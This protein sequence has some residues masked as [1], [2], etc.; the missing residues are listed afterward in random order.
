MQHRGQTSRPVSSKIGSSIVEGGGG[1]GRPSPT[2]AVAVSTNA[3]TKARHHRHTSK[4]KRWYSDC[5]AEQPQVGSLC[6]LSTPRARLRRDRDLCAADTPR[7]TRARHDHPIWRSTVYPAAVHTA[8]APAANVV[9]QPQSQRVVR[10]RAHVCAATPGRGCRQRKRNAR[11]PDPQTP[12]DRSVGRRLGW[13]TTARAPLPP[14]QRRRASSAATTGRPPTPKRHSATVTPT[15]NE[16]AVADAGV[17]GRGH[18]RPAAPDDCSVG[19]RLGRPPTACASLPLTPPRHGLR[20]RET[21]DLQRSRRRA[22]SAATTGWP[23]TP[24]G[25]RR[26]VGGP[27]GADASRGN[28]DG[29]MGARRATSR[30]KGGAD[31]KPGWW[32]VLCPPRNEAPCGRHAG[33]GVELLFQFEAQFDGLTMCCPACRIGQAVS[34]S[35]MVDVRRD[36][37]LVLLVPTLVYSRGHGPP[38]L[39]APSAP[40][41]S[42]RES[43]CFGRANAP[44]RHQRAVTRSGFRPASATR[45][46]GREGWLR[47]TV[48]AG[49]GA[50]PSAQ[51]GVR[52]T[53]ACGGM[54]D[55]R[56]RMPSLGPL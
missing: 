10:C 26:S 11:K 1:L 35:S 29:A 43:T 34:R 46:G 25:T 40:S 18:A 37:L 55:G 32:R 36:A 20:G 48:L 23:P 8:R 2:M 53:D 47:L 27:G 28:G 19:R 30:T 51:A 24:N 45:S 15:G 5:R 16:V 12:D 31:K 41:L 21:G 6:V 42:L 56:R 9:R 44:P 7:P 4:L 50:V 3:A 49:R 52:P 33:A 17:L 14:T 39:T 13:P 54:G 38:R 22:S